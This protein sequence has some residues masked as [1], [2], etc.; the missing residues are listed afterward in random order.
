M[1]YNSVADGFHIN[2]LSSRLSSSKMRF[3]TENGRFAFLS[4][5]FG[6][7]GATHDV[8]LR[9]IGKRIVVFLLVL[10]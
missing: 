9:L 10:I 8:H 5:P 3:Y 7:L 4:P 2:K 1:P 6:D